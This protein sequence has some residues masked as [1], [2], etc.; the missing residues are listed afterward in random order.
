MYLQSTHDAL[1][2][3]SSHVYKISNKDV[4]ASSK[5]HQYGETLPFISRHA[6]ERLH[7]YSIG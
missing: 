2:C 1:P 7:V 6:L 5:S 4:E 3:R